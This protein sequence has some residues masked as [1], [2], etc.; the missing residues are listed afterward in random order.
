MA[1][2]PEGEPLH[3]Q[4][5]SLNSSIDAPR[6]VQNYVEVWSK[7]LLSHVYLGLRQNR[8]SA[9]RSESLVEGALG[10]AK[11]EWDKALSPSLRSALGRMRLPFPRQLQAE[12]TAE[13]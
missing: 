9:Q 4:L 12:T 7:F 1:K 6:T 13:D 10:R 11:E 3:P 8:V 2:P 5:P